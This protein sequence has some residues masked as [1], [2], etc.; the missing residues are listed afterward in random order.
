MYL[1]RSRAFV[2]HSL[3]RRDRRTFCPITLHDPKTAVVRP[4]SPR[5]VRDNA[6]YVTLPPADTTLPNVIWELLERMRNH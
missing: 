1:A 5:W 3:R 4:Y 6:P 2:I